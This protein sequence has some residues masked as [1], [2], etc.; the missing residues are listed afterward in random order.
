M[1]YALDTGVRSEAAPKRSAVCQYCGGAMVA[2]CGPL[3]IWHWAHVP[4]RSCDPWWEPETHW[5]RQWKSRFPPECQ[6][7]VHLDAVSNEKH[8]AD[9]KTTKLLVIELQN[10]AIRLD[11]LHS[12]ERFYK[13]MVWVVNGAPFRDRFTIMDRMPSPEAEE[14]V[15]IRIMTDYNEEHYR[16]YYRVSEN[17]FGP[18]LV[19]AHPYEELRQLVDKRY[20]GEHLFSWKNMRRIWF[21]ATKPVFFDF[22]DNNL[23]QLLSCHENRLWYIKITSKKLFV[24]SNGGRYNPQEAEQRIL[25]RV[26]RAIM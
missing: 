12:R 6:E 1:K 15:D 2:K 16:G 24:E 10:S 4:R 9:V 17:R 18:G 25:C 13:E 7:V 8:V 23:Y 14:M 5:H 22:G 26:G 20:R 11:E 19:I 3:R 21:K